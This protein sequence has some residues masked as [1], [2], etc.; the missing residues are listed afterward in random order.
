MIGKYLVGLCAV[1]VCCT[2]A[3]AQNKD[4]GESYAAAIENLRQ[5]NSGFFLQDKLAEANLDS[6]LTSAY[7]K[8]LVKK[9]GVASLSEAEIDKVIINKIKSFNYGQ[10]AQKVKPNTE[11]IKV[12]Y[13]KTVP[14]LHKNKISKAV[15]SGYKASKEIAAKK[16]ILK[17]ISDNFNLLET[18][19]K[20]Q[21]AGLNLK[22]TFLAGINKAFYS[23]KNTDY[24][25][26]LKITDN[27]L[28]K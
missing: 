15:I 23:L 9:V 22:Y 20:T 17:D 14:H 21:V 4:M 16:E 24:E 18:K 2:G 19:Y 28:G 26:A 12:N 6:V 1:A 10:E 7:N 11:V 3:F 8:A 25:N 5:G 27:M 13:S